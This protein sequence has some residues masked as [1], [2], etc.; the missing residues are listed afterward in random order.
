MEIAV[1]VLVG[2]TLL[3][4]AAI[5]YG[6]HLSNLI[7][8][9]SLL[10]RHTPPP[11]DL[12]ASS[13]GDERITL[14]AASDA[15]GAMD[16]RRDGVFGIITADGYGQ[17]GD[18]LE[19]GDGY[20]VR[21]YTPLTA[22]IRAAE[23]ARL[24]IYAY[25]D[26]PQ[27]AHGIAYDE[28]RYESEL[29][30]CPAWFIPGRGSTWVVFAHGRGAHPDEALR[31]IPTLAEAGLP[32]LAITYRNDE[33]APRS[34]DRWHW[35]GMTEWRDMEAA[36]RY[37]LNNGAERI[38]LYG[39]SMGGGMCLKMLYESELAGKVRGVVMD[40]PLLDFRATLEYGARIR[41]YP[42]FIIPYARAFAGLR[43]GI[44]WERMNY[45]TRASELQAPILLLHGEADSLVPPHT[46]R[47]LMRARPDIV[48]YVGFEGV[49]HARS[50]NGDSGRYEAAVRAFL[51]DVVP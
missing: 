32:T 37:A 31:I 6:V 49:E 47:A 14:R 19:R 51:Q 29:G 4:A 44:D 46:S 16:L 41:G 11:F 48:R 20:A 28:V 45:L 1:G 22:R 10:S 42:R 25:P 40:S 33:G 7:R 9:S 30:E 36:A 13:E 5:A 38:V 39:Y 21:E 23:P 43:F 15:A 34:H 2:V 17:V 8:D 3:L 18:I 50:W 24:D 26:N 35:L 27:T 12:I